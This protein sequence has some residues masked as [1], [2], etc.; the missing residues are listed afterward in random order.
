MGGS[1]RFLCW[2]R[3]RGLV[4]LRSAERSQRRG[5]VRWRQGADRGGETDRTKGDGK[6]K[7]GRLFTHHTTRRGPGAK[8]CP[9]KGGRKRKHS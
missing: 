5:L 2:R 4:E 9:G 3:R 8:S 6:G 1:V 7:P